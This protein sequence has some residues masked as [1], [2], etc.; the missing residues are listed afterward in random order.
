MRGYND[1]ELSHMMNPPIVD[2][3][4]PRF[5]EDKYAYIEELRAAAPYARTPDGDVIFLNQDDVAEVF[6]CRDFRF[7]F[8]LI[9]ET[10]SPYLARAIKHELLNMH[11]DQ[12][13][14]LSRLL[15]SALRDRVIE[16]M[17]ETIS[18]I[19]DELIAALPASGEIEFCSQFA[20]PLPARVLG[21]MFGLPYDDTEGFNDWIKIG[22][23][24]LDALQSGVG[25]EVVEDANR[26]IHSFLRKLLADRHNAPG[27]DLFSELITAELDGDRMTEDEIVFL[28]GE[29]ASAGVDT[30]RTQLPLILHALLTHPTEMA[31][32]RADPSLALRAVDEGM[33]FAPLP[34]AIPHAAT[35]NFTY[36][37]I[38]FK[39]G[40]LAFALVPAANRDPA[41]T[42]NPQ[43]FDITR[44]R[45]KHF[46]F[47]AGMHACPGAH[48]A[49]MEMSVA[50]QKL[51]SN[52]QEI[53]LSEPPEWEDGQV[54]RALRSLK[55]RIA[56]KAM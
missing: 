37:D 7:A 40:D 52:L 25:I 53:R 19:V 31:K 13:A 27:D 46:A 56:R 39:T 1:A 42:E 47:G 26:N 50:L 44:G 22:G 28:S 18:A 41:A 48:L 43:Q 45:A 10:R 34:W 36:K 6:L 2:L 23:R 30:T 16:G 15:K 35:R 11:G 21:P 54:G 3:R 38:E 32:L 8:N 9:D 51:L 12:H 5:D 17:R 20:D 24:K 33:R 55:V 29:L 49:R 14:R 4:S